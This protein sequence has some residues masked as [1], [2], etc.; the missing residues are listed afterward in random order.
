MTKHLI[1][2]LFLML[3]NIC[4]AAS[5]HSIHNQDRQELRDFLTQHNFR[6]LRTEPFEVTKKYILGQAL[7]FD[8]VLST[9]NDTSCA[10]CH[11]V[12]YG[13][14]DGMNKSIGTG[15][16]G[17]GVARTEA[18]IEKRHTRNSLGLWNR[19]NQTASSMFWDGRL[20]VLDPRKHIYRSPFDEYLPKSIEN[21]LA[22]QALVP[23]V[24]KGEM[25]ASN[26]V[27]NNPCFEPNT[28][29]ERYKVLETILNKLIGDPN[30]PTTNLTQI[31]YRKLFQKA[32]PKIAFDKLDVG[33][34]GNAIAHFEEI[35]FAT[36]DAAWDQYIR[37]EEESLTDQQVEG[38]L[39]FFGKAG[40]SICHNGPVFSDYAFHS[41]GIYSLKG[42]NEPDYGRFEVTN[43]END[44]FR[45]RTPS[46]RNTTLTAPYFHDGS[47]ANLKDS[48]E[49]HY[50]HSD[51]KKFNTSQFI[52][53][54]TPDKEEI[55]AIIAFLAALEDTIESYV[56]F[57]TPKSVP[58]GSAFHGGTHK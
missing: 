47:S 33:H 13:T 52:N 14:S 46:L 37:G 27:P 41:L 10:T 57:V 35:A 53:L 18:D 55:N 12:D 34:I 31:N 43:S 56:P 42:D 24:S 54:E 36:R 9:N 40:C 17:I 6:P 2:L 29:E 45:F 26:C 11:L 51:S 38:A 8:P 44:K 23:L 5:E 32:Y 48:I 19:D 39:L 3:I 7:F 50:Q 20:E 21:L 1:F 58:S 25:F 49:Q 28:P 30:S 15:G 16:K 22:A 4:E